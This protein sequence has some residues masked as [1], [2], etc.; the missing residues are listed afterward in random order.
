M[1]YHNYLHHSKKKFSKTT[2][3]DNKKSE[4]KVY[5]RHTTHIDLLFRLPYLYNTIA[6]DVYCSLHKLQ[7]ESDF[8]SSIQ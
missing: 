1:I 3:N 2:R 6:S 5:N 7:L 8:R 4:H